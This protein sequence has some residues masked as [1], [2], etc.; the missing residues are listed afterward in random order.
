MSEPKQENDESNLGKVRLK[1]DGT[2]RKELTEEQKQKRLD[3]LRKGREKAH[4][5]RREL[6]RLAKEGK[7]KADDNVEEKKEEIDEKEIPVSKPKKTVN[8][9]PKKK[10][11]VVEESSDSSSSEEEIIVTKKSKRSKKKPS[12]SPPPAPAPVAPTQPPF[13]INTPT[14]EEIENIRKEKIRK[15]KEQE[16]RDKFMASIFG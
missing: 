6:E 12:P 5:K 16:K 3:I 4:E 14:P 10:I 2:P 15:Y 8:K 9:K 11:I 13:K 7:L 1:K